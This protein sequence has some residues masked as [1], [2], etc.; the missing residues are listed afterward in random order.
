MLLLIVKILSTCLLVFMSI[1]FSNICIR[2][3]LKTFTCADQ[4]IA[5]KCVLG[6]IEERGLLYWKKMRATVDRP[7]TSQYL[8]ERIS[9]TYDLPYLGNILQK[10]RF[11][12]HIP[13][14]QTYTSSRKTNFFSWSRKNCKCFSPK[15]NATQ[16]N[17]LHASNP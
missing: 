13:F 14:C 7:N 9:A 3:N 10:A 16:N 1:L 4:C 6:T 8:K 15:Q 12:R 5:V 11:L 2:V 17:G